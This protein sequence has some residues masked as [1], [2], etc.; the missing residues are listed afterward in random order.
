MRA[1]KEVGG[2]M[3][4]SRKTLPVTVVSGDRGQ[5]DGGGEGVGDMGFRGR[6]IVA[7]EPMASSVAWRGRL[8]WRKGDSVLMWDG[9]MLGY[10]ILYSLRYTQNGPFLFD[11]FI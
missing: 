2:E 10:T 3:L 11:N 9:W 4:K 1:V 7:E 5:R 8:R 6:L